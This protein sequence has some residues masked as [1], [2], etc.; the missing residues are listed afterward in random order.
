M[1]I[2]DIDG[3]LANFEHRLHFITGGNSDWKSFISPEQVALDKP[4]PEAQRALKEMQIPQNIGGTAVLLTGRNEALREVTTKWLLEHYGIDVSKYLNKYLIM[5]KDGDDSLPTVYKAQA[6]QH[7]YK[8]F[9]DYYDAGPYLAFDDD[10]FMMRVYKEF[11]IVPFLAP[12]CWK[13]VA[14]NFDL[15]QES[16]FR[17]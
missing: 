16:Y 6:I 13:Y 8:Q 10:K 9:I 17:P 3:T 4:F 14:P 5:R 2:L 1:I 15:P 12:D 7:I 11:S